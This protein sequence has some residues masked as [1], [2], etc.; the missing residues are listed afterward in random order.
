MLVVTGV[1]VSEVTVLTVVDICT[2]VSVMTPS[3]SVSVPLPVSMVSI[4][5]SIMVGVWVPVRV[6]SEIP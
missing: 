2:V 5:F 4:K 6:V 3:V 1:W